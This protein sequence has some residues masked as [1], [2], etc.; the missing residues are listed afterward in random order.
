[1]KKIF[2]LTIICA[3][4]L[5]ILAAC[6]NEN[7]TE[8]PT[9]PPTEAPTTAPME[10]PTEQPTEEPTEQPTE[11]PSDAPTEN[12]TDDPTEPPTEDPT[13]DPT[14]DPTETPTEDPTEQ[15]T[16]KPT[17]DPTDEPTENQTT[18]PTEA[19]TDTPTEKPTEAPTEAPTEQPTEA[20]TEQPTETPIDLPD[21]YVDLSVRENIPLNLIRGHNMQPA[22]ADNSASLI[23]ADSGNGLADDPYIIMN[24]PSSEINCLQYPYFAMIVKTNNP[25]V[26]GELRFRTN[27]TGNNYPCQPISHQLTDDWQLIVCKLTDLNTVMHAP[28]NL[29]YIGNYTEVRLDLYDASSGGS[30]L[31]SVDTQYYIKAYAFFRT[32]E[33]AAEFIKLGAG[34]NLPN[35]E[36]PN[37]NYENFW[38]G[39][40]FQAPAN[41]KRM[42]WLAYGF[43]GSTTPVDRFLSEGYGGIVSNVNFNQNYLKDPNE[44]SILKKVY[45]YA[46]GKDMT[47]WIYDEYQW[48]SG[49]AYGLVLDHQ[50]GREWESTGIQHIV[51][52]GQGGTASYTLGETN[53]LRVDIGI[54]QAVLTDDNGSRNL[55]ISN[56][57][58]SAAASGSWRLDIYLLRYTYDGTENRYDFTTLRYVDLLNPDAVQCFIDVTHEQYKKYL[59]ESFE[60]ITAFFTDEPQL[61]NRGMADYVVWTAGFAERFYETYGYEINIPSLF[62]GSTTYDRAVRLNYYRLV[63]TMFKESYIDQ[64]TE[65]CEAN[66]VAS[67]GHLLFE[68]DMND[69]IET[70]GGNFMQV[71]GGMSIPGADVLWVDPHNLLRQN[72]IG[73]YMGLR[74]VSSAAKNSG[75]NDVMIEFNPNAVSAL[76]G[77]ADKLGVSI[78]GLSITR[79]L[80][81][82]IYNVINP[83]RDYTNSELNQLNTYIGRLNTILD[84]TV[85]C[86]ELGIFYPIATVQAYHDADSNHSSEFGSGTD[87]IQLNTNYEKICLY[88][89]QNQLLFTIL[90]DESICGAQITADGKMNIGLGS[91]STI[92]LPFTEYIS[93]EALTKLVEFQNAGGTVIFYKSSITHGLE[94][95]EEDE[96]AE[97]MSRITKNTANSQVALLRKI[98]ERVSTSITVTMKSGNPTSLLMGDFKNET[99]DVSFLVNT[100]GSDMTL[101]WRYTDGYTGSVNIYYPGSGKIETI[102]LSGED[103]TLVIPAFEGVLIV[104][105]P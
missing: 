5:G 37:V 104:R 55:N 48:P 4:M 76:D 58:V 24:M 97:I 14:D 41:S 68:E 51:L 31:V 26:K 11:E 89:L 22:V 49:K 9:E 82:N 64:I 74:Y 103:V 93:V 98:R 91:Y 44:F 92:V 3:L 69:H 73:N 57:S 65:W 19:P 54:M 102:N 25:S 67:S 50:P 105:E 18:A 46:A 71:V 79:L 13:E 40:E 38:L 47:L 21:H 35:E 10:Q 32:A 45:D 95:D 53:G 83:S 27:L 16:E 87:A 78:G 17:E 63:A 20:P 80:G 94:L 75:K 81:T 15:P 28:N 33:E 85:E 12:P 77:Y 99:H 61:G 42:N 30:G 59:G 8:P 56:N 43:R 29:P 6:N 66:G 72:F 39:K 96:I 2:A 86:G 52:T 23:F 34:G 84:E 60:N 101:D 62:S 90:D 36:T 1:M 7:P 88:L 100:A 70:Y